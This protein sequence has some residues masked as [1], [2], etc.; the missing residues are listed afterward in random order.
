MHRE[1]QLIN[2]VHFFRGGLLSIAVRV[3]NP[4]MVSQL[5]A[6]GIDPD[7]SVVSTDDGSRSWGAPL[8][9]A[10]MCGR[11]EIA[12]TLL[13]HGADVNAVL[14]ACGD[15]MSIAQTTADERFKAIL[16][17]HGARITVEHVASCGDVGLAQAILDGTTPA[18]SLNSDSPT[19]VELA[20]QMLLA[21]GDNCPEI[22]RLCLPHIDRPKDD[23]WWNYAMVRATDPQCLDHILR[24]GVNPSVVGENGFTLLHHI[25]TTTTG[26][27]DRLKLATILLDHGASLEQ[28]DLLLKS[29]PLG[30]ACRWGRRELVELYLS[31]GLDRIRTRR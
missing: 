20:E 7:E 30:W 25:A 1:N 8:W 15:A 29:T 14:Y 2:D 10:T 21:A 18:C 24:H 17:E 4:E 6:L 3:N 9:F 26:E 12:K 19:P 16:I 5:L 31:R 27:S 23:A 13:N 28:R 22:V 11:H